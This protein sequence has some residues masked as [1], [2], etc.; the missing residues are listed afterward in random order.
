[1]TDC[2][3][4]TMRDSSVSFFG[5]L[6]IEHSSVQGLKL[7]QLRGT[8]SSD[9]RRKRDNCSAQRDGTM[10]DSSVSFFGSLSIEHSSV[11]GVP[12][13]QLRGTSLPH[14][15]ECVTFSGTNH[16]TDPIP[17]K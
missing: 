6:S 4:G 9:I 16:K 12:L 5:S 14:L 2:W 3:G 10:R 13:K 11:Q 17:V 1:M 7:T 15:Q 8:S